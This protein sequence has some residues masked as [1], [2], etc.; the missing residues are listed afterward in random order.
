MHPHPLSH[1]GLSTLCL[2]AVVGIA[3]C[4]S[5]RSAAKASKPELAP[6]NTPK[7]PIVDL[8]AD[9]PCLP[10]VDFVHRVDAREIPEGRALAA[11]RDVIPAQCR[12][13][14]ANASLKTIGTKLLPGFLDF[15][16][17][18][19]EKTDPLYDEAFRGYL[20]RLSLCLL[21]PRAV[22]RSIDGRDVFE[23]ILAIYRADPDDDFRKGTSREL[24]GWSTVDNLTGCLVGL[25]ESNDSLAVERAKDILWKLLPGD[26]FS[27][28][29]EALLRSLGHHIDV[30]DSAATMALISRT[31]RSL[32]EFSYL[33]LCS[34]SRD[35]GSNVA[36]ICTQRLGAHDA[37]WFADK[38]EEMNR[39]ERAEQEESEEKKCSQSTRILLHA[40]M[41]IL[42]SAIGLG[43]GAI[44]IAKDYRNPHEGYSKGW[45]VAGKTSG[46]IAGATT[47]VALT[48]LYF[49]FFE[50]FECYS[51]QAIGQGAAIAVMDFA[52]LVA[53]A[54]AGGVAG[55]HAAQ[56]HGPSRTAALAT[57]GVL[58]SASVAYFA[59]VFK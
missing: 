46:A 7:P 14:V 23:T 36:G 27:F 58:F 41:R 44:A 48:L 3:G 18:W 57:T 54:V 34:G 9:N 49:Q 35:R 28:T 6:R 56:Y 26:T 32:G 45:A 47:G 17:F 50:G 42:L 16:E 55:G 39:A 25:V 24:A 12:E 30:M 43:F 29:D 31:R 19:R 4:V 21:A 40:T 51:H 8:A 38:R 20:S 11:L 22:L 53:G 59:F 10:L 13:E 15:L 1:H 37:Q 2:M 5:P 33:A 52:A